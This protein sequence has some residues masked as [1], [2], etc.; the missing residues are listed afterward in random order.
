MVICFKNSHLV[1][2]DF[3]VP[4]YSEHT[5]LNCAQDVI[6]YPN[7]TPMDMKEYLKQLNTRLL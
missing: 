3:E 4:S 7:R 6:C 2:V 5:V 1:I